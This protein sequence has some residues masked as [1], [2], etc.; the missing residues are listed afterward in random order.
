MSLNCAYNDSIK[1]LMGK[2]TTFIF[3]LKTFVSFIMKSFTIKKLNIFAPV[4][5]TQGNIFDKLNFD[6]NTVSYLFYTCCLAFKKL[7]SFPCIQVLMF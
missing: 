2:T 5:H 4:K 1:I 3:L 6:H 7:F